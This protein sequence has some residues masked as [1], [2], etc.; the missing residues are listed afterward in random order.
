MTIPSPPTPQGSTSRRDGATFSGKDMKLSGDG[1]QLSQLSAEETSSDNTTQETAKGEGMKLSKRAYSGVANEFWH[2]S[3]ISF[4]KTREFD[5]ADGEHKP[6]EKKY[7][8]SSDNSWGSGQTVYIMESSP[9]D[10]VLVSFSHRQ[11][12][13]KD[14][15]GAADFGL[16]RLCSRTLLYQTTDGIAR[17]HL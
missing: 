13:T 5:K 8:Y 17:C 16:T 4:P 3:H 2:L 10:D 6:A 7:L 9:Y 1:A 11:P 14:P 15:G 12:V